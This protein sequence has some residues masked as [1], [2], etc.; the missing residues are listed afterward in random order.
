MKSG[1]TLAEV[2]VVVA[3]VLLL[4]TGLI[5]GA[6]A[7][8]KA[9]QFS[10][11][12]S[13][14]VRYAEEAVELGRG[15]RDGGWDTFLAYGTTNGRSWCLDKAGTWTESTGACPVNIDSVYTRKV[16]FTWQDPKMKID[17]VLSWQEGGKTFTSDTTTYLTQ[18]R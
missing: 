7:S 3:V 1:Q 11:A 18:W 13:L 14:S 4:I 16:T 17:V 5:A 8:L 15:L 6:T 12:K 9:S 10:R 2:I